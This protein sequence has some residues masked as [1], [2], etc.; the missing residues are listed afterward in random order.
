L[1]GKS[2]TPKL[3]TTPGGDGSARSINSAGS[4]T[5]GGKLRN[6]KMKASAE[7]SMV[8]KRKAKDSEEGS[9]VES[10]L[11]SLYQT[12][13]KKKTIFSFN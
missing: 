12:S 5:S 9:L 4:S 13:R 10:K 3:G 11:K 8:A 1:I 7:A 6:L 2:Y